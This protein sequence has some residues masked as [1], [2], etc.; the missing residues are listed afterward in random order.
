MLIVARGAWTRPLAVVPLW[1]VVPC[2]AT[3]DDARGSRPQPLA[4]PQ[5]PCDVAVRPAMRPFPGPFTQR[6]GREVEALF[7]R[8]ALPRRKGQRTSFAE[9]LFLRAFTQRERAEAQA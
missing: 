6:E 7:E 4:T 3:V 8:C 5:T 9:T 1:S 2:R